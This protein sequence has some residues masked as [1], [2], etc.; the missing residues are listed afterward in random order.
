LSVFAYRKDAED[1]LWLPVILLCHLQHHKELCHHWWQR[2][3]NMQQFQNNFYDLLNW[4][5]KNNLH[6]TSFC[7]LYLQNYSVIA[8][9]ICGFT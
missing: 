8:D 1:L 5:F 9:S 7:I 4:Q 3:A 2:N 6:F